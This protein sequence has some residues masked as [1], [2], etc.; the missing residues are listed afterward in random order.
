MQLAQSDLTGHLPESAAANLLA[1]LPTYVRDRIEQ[2]AERTGF[3]T[4]FILEAA[5]SN[6][7]D[8]DAT[9][10]K[11]FDPAFDLSSSN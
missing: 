5:I 6:Y 8:P 3:P 9:S 2:E 11:D 4:W 1:L 7:L 10:F